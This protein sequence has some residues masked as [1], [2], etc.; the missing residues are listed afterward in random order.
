[1]QARATDNMR[2]HPKDAVI[3]HYDPARYAVQVDFQPEGNTSGWIPLGAL[4]VGDGWGIFAA[5]AIGTA[6]EVEFT[7]GNPEAG[8][9]GLSFFSNVDQPLSVQSG[10]LWMVHKTGSALK[11]HNDGSVDVVSNQNM[12]VTVGGNLTANVTGN[13]NSTVDG[14]VTVSVTGN[15]QAT[16][17]GTMAFTAPTITLNGAI[18]L[19]GPISQTNT[20]GA[21]TTASL[22]GPVTVTNDVTAAGI[23]L[24]THPHNVPN[25]QGGSS[26]LP[27]TAPL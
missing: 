19:D 5:P 25:V 12:N 7:D 18:V 14:S 17:T 9:C 22:I 21:G 4:W 10:E 20:G 8:V 23:S 13:V 15:V 16:A 11:F 1:M 24:Q 27:T 6:V 2:S 3:S 26:T